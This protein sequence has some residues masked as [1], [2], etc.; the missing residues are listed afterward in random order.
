MLLLLS[1]IHLC[2]K[3]YSV[4]ELGT[5][6]I[7]IQHDLAQNYVMVTGDLVKLHMCHWLRSVISTAICY[8]DNKVHIIAVVQMKVLKLPVLDT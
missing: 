6:F 8:T 1:F 4:L 5:L 2:L 7:L 3:V